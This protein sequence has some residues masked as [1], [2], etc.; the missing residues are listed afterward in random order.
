MSTFLS[1]KKKYQ[2]LG[3]SDGGYLEAEGME[4]TWTIKQESIA[5][6][7]EISSSRNRYDFGKNESVS[8][9]ET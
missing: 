7:V 8:F 3:P 1:K 2:Y 6:D 5:R 4:K 9:I